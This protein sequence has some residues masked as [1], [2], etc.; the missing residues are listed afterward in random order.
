MSAP[1]A[2]LTV[3]G[4]MVVVAILGPTLGLTLITVRRVQEHGGLVQCQNNL[5]NLT[6]GLLGSMTAKGFFPA[7]AEPNAEL[8]VGRRLSW[9]TSI[10]AYFDFAGLYGA[11][12]RS[13][14]WDD[15]GNLRFDVPLGLLRC[16]CAPES[17]P[18]GRTQFVG[19]TGLGPDSPWL[20]AGHPRAGVFGFNRVTRPGDVRDGL[21]STLLIVETAARNGPW[22][23][24]GDPTVRPVDPALR[25]HIGPGRPF[26]GLHPGGVNAAFADGSVRFLRGSIDPRVFEALATVAGGEPLPAGWDR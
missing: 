18:P 13:A 10:S 1:F 8:P 3:R 22:T 20:P 6:L 5:R 16:P 7:A 11:F 2:R 25:P 24:G 4:M 19:I 9:M 21:G 17:V 14:P 23:A 26:G 15:P 12:D